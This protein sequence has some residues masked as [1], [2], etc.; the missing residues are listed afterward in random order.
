MMRMAPLQEPLHRQQVPPVLQRTVYSGR[1]IFG[2]LNERS[3]GKYIGGEKRSREEV[4]R[5]KAGD[6]HIHQERGF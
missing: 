1:G 4:K 2:V 5:F 3:I 6:G